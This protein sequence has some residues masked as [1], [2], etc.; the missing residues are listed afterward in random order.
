[1]Y[2]PDNQFYLLTLQKGSKS[3][4]DQLRNGVRQ[5]NQQILFNK[6]MEQYGVLL[7]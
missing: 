3:E 5:A 7:R 1:M 4:R 6:L 2:C